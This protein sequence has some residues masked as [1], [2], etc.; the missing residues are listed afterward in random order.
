MTRD[1]CNPCNTQWST[2]RDPCDPCSAQR[3]VARRVIPAI[4]KEE[5]QTGFP[6]YHGFYTFSLKR[7]SLKRY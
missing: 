5:F 7:L 4:I 2:T 1:P 3:W 6:F